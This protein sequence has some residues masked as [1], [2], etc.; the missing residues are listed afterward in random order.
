MALRHPAYAEL[1]ALAAE[2]ARLAGATLGTL[3]EGGNGVG[4]VAAGAV[5][6]RDAAGG[7]TNGLDALAML[8]S[9]QRAYLLVGA[10][11]PSQDL[12][13]P[14]AAAVA[15]G[16]AACVV[17]V[18]PFASEELLRHAHVLLPMAAFAETS[19]TY[20]NLEG[21]WQS[22]PGAVVPPGEA[23]PGWKILR[24]LGNLLQLQGF[25]EESS[26]QV[27]ERLRAQVDAAVGAGAGAATTG[28]AASVA[29]PPALPAGAAGAGSASSAALD[30]PMYAIDAV[31]R[32]SPALQATHI[33][34][35]SRAA[36]GAA[37]EVTA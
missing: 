33:A 5:P 6:Y 34:R 25:D 36:A 19:G 35:A 23:R 15:F 37:A 21:R 16:G 17:A 13:D 9:P 26:E 3:V 14:A 18:T 28:L 11:E 7:A 8:R 29:V 20:V 30:I 4:A 24:V 32:R 2:T 1:R 12:A 27:R 31:L 22:H 10:I